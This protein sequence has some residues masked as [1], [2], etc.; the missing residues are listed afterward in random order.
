MDEYCTISQKLRLLRM[1]L[2]AN[3]NKMD[4]IASLLEAG[5]YAKGMR[6]QAIAASVSN[7]HTPGY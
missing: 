2:G 5:A 3:M 6:Q 1:G 4:S 7:L